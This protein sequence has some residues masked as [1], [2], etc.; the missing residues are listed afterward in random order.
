MTEDGVDSVVGDVFPT[1][2]GLTSDGRCM[3]LKEVRLQLKKNDA[4]LVSMTD[5]SLPCKFKHEKA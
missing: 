3:S 5:Q 1:L 4:G 2:G